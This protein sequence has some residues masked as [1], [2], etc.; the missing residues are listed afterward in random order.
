MVKQVLSI[1]KLWKFD[2]HTSLMSA[3]VERGRR[4]FIDKKH[5]Y[6]KNLEESEI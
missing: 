2:L 6:Y 3:L 5:N 1:L 4:N